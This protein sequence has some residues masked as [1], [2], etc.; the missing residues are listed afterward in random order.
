MLPT[1]IVIG[2]MKCGTSSLF[3]YLELHPEIFMSRLEERNKSIHFFSKSETY[4][5]GIEWYESMFD[6]QA[7]AYGESSGSYTKYPAFDGV[8]ERMHSIL[9]NVKLLYIVRDP[10]ERMV[11]HYNHRLYRGLETRAVDETLMQLERNE[12][13]NCSKY[14]MQISRY[15]PYFD[16]E[17]IL[18][19]CSEEL[20]RER[21]PTLRRVFEFIDVDGSFYISEYD[22]L[23]HVTARKFDRA[24]ERQSPSLLTKVTSFLSVNN[25]RRRGPATELRP[26][27]RARLVEQL[28]DDVDS[29]RRFT[30]QDFADWQL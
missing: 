22:K 20:A 21:K 11:S 5:R 17:R 28:Q 3:R 12:I 6:G 29:L 13:L 25:D 10:I 24:S 15:L 26:D 2:A 1:F 4:A 14:Y 9:P 27:T 7:K 8:P 18:I 23:S 30:G 16:D 19:I